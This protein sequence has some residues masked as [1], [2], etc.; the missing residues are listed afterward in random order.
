MMGRHPEKESP[1]SYSY[2][3]R[4]TRGKIVNPIRSNEQES[5]ESSNS[6]LM[7][8]LW[9][10]SP[11]DLINLIKDE[12]KIA[13]DFF[14]QTPRTFFKVLIGKTSYYRGPLASESSTEQDEPP[15]PNQCDSGCGK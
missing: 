7:G 4:G 14:I 8:T 12:P 3:Y 10:S 13:L 9:L 2:H 6:Q 15:P 11:L 1:P 5:Q